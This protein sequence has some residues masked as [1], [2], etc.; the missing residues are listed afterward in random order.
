MC[1]FPS[2]GKIEDKCERVIK[3]YLSYF[4]EY[5]L[6]YLRGDDII[7]SIPSDEYLDK[8][9]MIFTINKYLNGFLMK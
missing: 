3:K 5:D 2:I 1:H 4:E 9:I 7:S 8:L 6:K